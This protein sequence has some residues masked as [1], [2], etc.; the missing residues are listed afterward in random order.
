MFNK[1]ISGMVILFTGLLTGCVS[2]RPPP[3]ATPSASDAQPF[4]WRAKELLSLKNW[5]IRGSAAVIQPNHSDSVNYT[6][7]QNSENYEIQLAGALNLGSTQISGGAGFVKVEQADGQ[8]WEGS[9]P[10]ALIAERLGIRLPVAE[11]VYWVRGIPAAESYTQLKTDQRGCLESLQQ[12]G[13]TIH[14]SHYERV[15][16]NDLPHWIVLKRSGWTIKLLIR[17]WDLN[18]QL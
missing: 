3:V 16:S 6:W 1:Q 11:L 12:L 17:D 9:N 10:N 7:K 4:A 15:G 2:V 5:I 8:H 14:W 13:W 18:T